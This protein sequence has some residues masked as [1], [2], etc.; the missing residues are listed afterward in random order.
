MILKTWFLN[1]KQ[2]KVKVNITR[3]IYIPWKLGVLFPKQST[4]KFKFS[5]ESGYLENA[6][7]FCSNY[8]IEE[9]FFANFS[10]ESDA[11][12]EADFRFR[13]RFRFRFLLLHFLSL[14]FSI[15]LFFV[16]KRTL[17]KLVANS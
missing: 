17:M 16:I 14:S 6:K 3:T 9:N 11:C 2:W 7:F 10:S 8:K 5:H 12:K 15:I 13:F 4:S 1:Q